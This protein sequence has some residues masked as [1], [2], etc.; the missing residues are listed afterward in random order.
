MRE[1]AEQEIILPTGPH[2]G[3]KFR[4]DRQP[5]TALFFDAVD[6]GKWR[7]FFTT[8]PQQSGKTLTAS[9]IPLLY[10]LFEV[11]ETV[12]FGLPTLD[13]VADKWAEDIRPAIEATKYRDFLP[14]RGHGSKGG[15]VRRIEFRNGSTLRFMVGGGG[16]KSRAGFT[17]RVL[18]ITEVDG[19]DESGGTSREADKIAQ[20]E[21]RTAAYGDRAR[22]YGECTVSV[23]HGRTWREYTQGTESKVV[24]RCPHCGKHVCPERSNL[25]GWKDAENE[26]EAA[27]LSSL[28]CYECGVKWSEAD[29]VAANRECRLIHRGQKI[30]ESG[31]VSGSI[32]ETSTLGFRW[33]AA[34]NLLVPIS[35]IGQREWKA[36]RAVDESNAEK[37]MCQF[38]WAMPYKPDSVEITAGNAVEITK[39]AVSVPRGVCPPETQFVTVGIDI[40]MYLCHWS[41]IAWKP[42][43]T[44]H[45]VE[46]GRLE[47]PSKELGV[48]NGL[49][50]ALRQF[51]DEVDKAGWRG[52]NG[53]I[54]P[55]LR[56]VDAGWQDEIVSRFCEESGQGWFPTKGVGATR[57]ENVK[58]GEKKQTGSRIIQVGEGYHVAQLPGWRVP[59]VEV[60]SDHWKTWV[61]LR[62]QTPVGQDGGLTL[63]QGGIDHLTFAKHL[64]AEKKVEEFIAGKGLVS[65]WEAINRNNHYL[66]S[67][68]LACVAGH[69]AGARLV[70]DIVAA[71][72]PAPT[73]TDDSLSAS[74]WISRANKW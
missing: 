7:R 8:G 5:F 70:G 56:F 24:I 44:P 4:C 50:T 41:L 21:G 39:R 28:I 64:T 46:Y 66:D 33:T 2:Q 72:T 20:L 52:P 11:R 55:T 45:V 18:I 34:N 32:P 38:V 16:D 25:I 42:N 68:C 13:M 10:H 30:E 19:M 73:Q 69:A 65:R 9:I 35:M 71:P 26:I 62:L 17:S 58:G 3:R 23:E 15:N 29:R 40:G 53:Q 61:H 14:L 54:S 43:A 60:Q 1:F 51:R 67:T 57:Y 49:L 22:V 74:Q 59:L 63:F 6:S 31:V 47:V 27:K 36:S 12:I 37:E 48:E